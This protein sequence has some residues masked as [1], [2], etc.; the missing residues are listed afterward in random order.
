MKQH[1]ASRRRPRR[2]GLTCQQVT[3][4]ILNYVMGEL[5]PRTALAL[6]VH[7]RECSDCISFL[8]T[9]TKTIQA[10]N[11]LRYENVP[12]AMRKRV[13]LFLRTKIAEAPHAAAD[14]AEPASF[15]GIPTDV[16][17]KAIS[18]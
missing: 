9:Y 6:K 15:P 17:K 5:H 1:T 3:G 4:L 2:V 10:T 14:P 7:L 11:S 12:Q 18:G 8:A 13:R 16:L